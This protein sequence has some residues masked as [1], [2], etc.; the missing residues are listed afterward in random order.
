MAEEGIHRS[1]GDPILRRVL[2]SREWQDSDVSEIGE[3]VQNHDDSA[4][5]E[6]G[7]RKIFSRIAHFAPN[8]SYVGPGRLG[9][10]RADHRS[11]KKKGEREPAD[12]TKSGLRDL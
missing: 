5:G 9:K 10:K 3:Q 1:D 7:A 6:Q 12:D 2:D 11:A 4:A 8:E